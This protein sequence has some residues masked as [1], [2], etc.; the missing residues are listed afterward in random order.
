MADAGMSGH[1]GMAGMSGSESMPMDMPMDMMGMHGTHGAVGM[2]SAHLLAALRPGH[3]AVG[4]EQAVFRVGRAALRPARR[5]AARLLGGP[6]PPPG[7]RASA[8]AW[9]ARAPAAAAA[10]RARPGHTGST[11]VRAVCC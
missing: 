7:R 3:L 6:L 1:S 10:V 8:P 2:W 9:P 11:A 4:R 5:P